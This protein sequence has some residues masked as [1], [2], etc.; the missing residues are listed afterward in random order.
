VWR[1]LSM[2]HSHAGYAVALKTM[3]NRELSKA[4]F[5]ID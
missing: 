3:A 4:H 1:D 2:L 5:G